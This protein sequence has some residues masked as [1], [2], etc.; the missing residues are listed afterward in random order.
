MA[1]NYQLKR[2]K[3]TYLSVVICAIAVSPLR[4]PISKQIV[5]FE[6][7]EHK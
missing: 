7:G 4:P 5:R 2:T 1:A 3:F 6:L